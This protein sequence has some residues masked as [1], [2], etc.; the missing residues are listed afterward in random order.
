MN[1]LRIVLVFGLVTSSASTAAAAIP[2]AA[3]QRTNI[4]FIG[5]VLPLPPSS[6]TTELPAGTRPVMVRVDEAMIVPEAIV[7]SR[8]DLVT[9]AVSDPAA[10]PVGTRD[11]FYTAGVV[12]GRTITVREI[13]HEAAPPA[14]A[15]AAKQA[16]IKSE[17]AEAEMERNVRGTDA[18]II[19]N[20]VKV[21]EPAAGDRDAGPISEH[22]PEWRD[23]QVRVSEWVKG[24]GPQIVTV[25][26]P[27]SIDVMWASV[28]KLKAG[29][30]ELLFLHKDDVST[31]MVPKMKAPAPFVLLNQT[32]EKPLADAPL[33]RKVVK[34]VSP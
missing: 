18:I 20:V 29:T 8:G 33:A 31:E 27:A 26:F 34:K 32:D 16:A 13:A 21:S 17:M 5:E 3:L 15:V 7:L 23:A 28:P 6:A 1:R 9:V 2:T 25:R 4:V 22:D 12:F 30:R 10:F 11:I 14:G 19:G 24:S